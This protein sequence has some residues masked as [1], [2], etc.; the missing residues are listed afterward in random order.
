MV[1]QATHIRKLTTSTLFYVEKRKKQNIL[2]DEIESHFYF[3]WN[4]DLF[5]KSDAFYLFVFSWN[6][7][8]MKRPL[9][10]R[11]EFFMRFLDFQ[12]SLLNIV[13]YFYSVTDLLFIIERVHTTIW[14]RRGN[15]DLNYRWHNSSGRTTWL[16]R[17]ACNTATACRLITQINQVA[18]LFVCFMCIYLSVRYYKPA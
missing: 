13:G 8:W 11:D 12:N 6:V 1:N 15:F 4:W 5:K 17:K 7:V 9:V 18:V 2:K 14:Q 3:F 16:N 10:H